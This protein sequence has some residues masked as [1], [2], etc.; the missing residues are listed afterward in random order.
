M[1]PPP[2]PTTQPSFTVGVPKECKFDKFYEYHQQMGYTIK[3]CITLLNKIQD[4][5]DQNKVSFQ[6]PKLDNQPKSLRYPHHDKKKTNGIF[7][8]IFLNFM[9]EK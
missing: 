5:N 2:K 8:N 3:Y 6:E 7:N 4:L 9:K 1:V